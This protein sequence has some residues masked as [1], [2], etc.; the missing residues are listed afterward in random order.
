MDEAGNAAA[1]GPA[2]RSGDSGPERGL[3]L[4]EQSR[5]Q[6][7]VVYQRVVP[8]RRSG[9]SR[10]RRLSDAHR[11]HQG[12]DQSRRREDRAAGNRRSSA[13]PSGGGRGGGVRRAASH[14]G[15]RSGR[16]GGSQRGTRPRRTN[17]RF[18]L[19]AKSGWRTSS[20]PRRSTSALRSRAPRRAKSSA[21]RWPKR[22]P[23]PDHALPDRRGGRHRRLHR[24]LAGA[25][26]PGRH[27]LRARRSPAGHRGT[28]TAH[29]QRRRRF[30]SASENRRPAS[31]GPA[32]STSSFW[33]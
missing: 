33:A 10:R 4:R 31:A 14:L 20:A 19:T 32:R 3:R 24:R 17:P 29:R 22:S 23:G 13:E 11:P 6:R 18:W 28:R 7:Q 1:H 16:G 5:G 8:H 30:P 12:T 26:R 25:R 21:A 9:L 27:A 2:R 15:R